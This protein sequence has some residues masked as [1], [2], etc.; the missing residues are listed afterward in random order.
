MTI[1]SDLDD[2][3]MAALAGL[4]G[5]WVTHD[6]VCSLTNESYKDV[7]ASVI[8]LMSDGRVVYESRGGRFKKAPGKRE[9]TEFETDVEIIQYLENQVEPVDPTRIAR[10]IGAGVRKVKTDLTR[11]QRE[12]LVTCVELEGVVGGEFSPSLWVG[13]WAE[14]WEVL[15]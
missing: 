10:A 6:D 15:S 13:G 2:N 5:Q 3:I 1:D 4:G 14:G 8:R 9:P 12:K 11:L 7:A